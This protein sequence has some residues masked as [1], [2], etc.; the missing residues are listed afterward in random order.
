MPLIYV[1]AAKAAKSPATPPPK[2]ITPSERVKPC[3]A[4]N[5]HSFSTVDKFLLASPAG[6]VKVKTSNPS[7]LNWETASLP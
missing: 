3:K 6:K 7:F 2:A 4:Q 1:L 5:S